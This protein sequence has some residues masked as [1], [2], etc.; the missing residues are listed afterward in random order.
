MVAEPTA[1]L[2]LIIVAWR[3]STVFAKASAK[4]LW[5]AFLR[6]RYKFDIHRSRT[7]LDEEVA[8]GRR[9]QDQPG[10]IVRRRYLQALRDHAE[11]LPMLGHSLPAQGSI[12]NHF[13]EPKL[14]Q[15]SAT[16]PSSSYLGPAEQLAIGSHLI[17]APLGGGKTSLV[18][19]ITLL[20][21]KRCLEASDLPSICN[22]RLPVL[23]NASQL[24]ETG[25][26]FFSAVREA[27]QSTLAGTILASLPNEFF[28]PVHKDGH[29]RWLL[30][31]DGLNQI[32]DELAWQALWKTLKTLPARTGGAFDCLVT[33]Q[34]WQSSRLGAHD[35]TTW[36]I[37]EFSDQNFLT[38]C[39]Q[40]TGDPEK[41]TSMIALV[42]SQGTFR[43]NRSP[44]FATLCSLYYS[45]TGSLPYRKAELL[46]WLIYRL[47][48]RASV[49]SVDE[50]SVLRLLTT[51]A[52]KPDYKPLELVEAFNELRGSETE[53]EYYHRLRMLIEKSGLAQHNGSRFEFNHSSIQTFLKAKS[54]AETNLPHETGW[55]DTAGPIFD[56]DTLSFVF[57]LWEA[58]GQPTSPALKTLARRGDEGFEAAAEIS[59][60]LREVSGDI[61]VQ[62]ASRIITDIN[63]YGSRYKDLE[64]LKRLASTERVAELI[65]DRFDQLE[66][67]QSKVE[68]LGCLVS[69]GLQNKVL[70]LLRSFAKS[71]DHYQGARLSA[72]TLILSWDQHLAKEVFYELAEA[73]DEA[74]VRVEAAHEYHKLEKT[75]DS[76]GLLAAAIEEA[77]ADSM[78]PTS[79][80][81]ELLSGGERDLALAWLRA[82][83]KPRV[84]NSEFGAITSSQVEAA[85]AIANFDQTEGQAA[86]R[87]LVSSDLT[88]PLVGLQAA[89]ALVELGVG[90]EGKNA[91][92]ALVK[93]DKDLKSINATTIRRLM[94][95][96]LEQDAKEVGLEVLKA[97]ISNQGRHYQ[98]KEILRSLRGLV[99][100]TEIIPLLDAHLKHTRDAYLLVCLAY[101]GSRETAVSRLKNWAKHAAPLLRVSSSIALCELG[102]TTVGRRQL[103]KILRSR[104]TCVDVR[105]AA[106]RGLVDTAGLKIDLSPYVELLKD[107][108][109]CLDT[110]LHAAYAIANSKV[111]GFND[112]AWSIS[113]DLLAGDFSVSDRISILKNMLKFP[114]AAWDDGDYLDVVDELYGLFREAK[115]DTSEWWSLAELLFDQSELSIDQILNSA[116]SSLSNQSASS[117][118]GL[119]SRRDFRHDGRVIE[120]IINSIELFEVPGRL[121]AI[122]A[123][124]AAQVSPVRLKPI[125]GAYFDN[126]DIPPEWKFKLIALLPEAV[127]ELIKLAESQNLTIDL[128]LRAVKDI[129]DLGHGE[130]AQLQLRAFLASGTLE[131]VDYVD[132]LDT[133]LRIEA[134]DVC[135]E[136]VRLIMDHDPTAISSV[137]ESFLEF[138][139]SQRAANVLTQAIDRAKDPDDICR[140]VQSVST[141]VRLNRVDTARSLLGNIPTAAGIDLEAD[142]ASAWALVD[143]QVSEQLLQSLVQKLQRGHGGYSFSHWIMSI[144]T[145]YEAGAAVDLSILFG[146]IEDENLAVRDRLTALRV[147]LAA[148]MGLSES[149]T[150]TARSVILNLLKRRLD[151]SSKVSL[152]RPMRELDMDAFTDSLIATLVEDATGSNLARSDLG[153][154]LLRDG[155]PLGLR[156]GLAMAMV[157]AEFP[158]G[159][160][161]RHYVSKT[162]GEQKMLHLLREKFDC[163][164]NNLSAKVAAAADL[165]AANGDP[166]A[167]RFMKSVS[168]EQTE[169][170]SQFVLMAEDALFEIGFVS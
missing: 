102:M 112:L 138:D 111:D 108:H 125:I 19:W 25:Q 81:D 137:A 79:I 105:L 24:I 117:A 90:D 32:D 149:Q 51:V 63:N 78:H 98:I 107:D 115:P 144:E 84:E 71:Q 43:L 58:S 146:A 75:P 153:L 67:E 21:C 121:R 7:P 77:I 11:R 133:A 61:A 35:F 42:K 164:Q 86:L 145:V 154:L 167:V 50:K 158:L 123:L 116:E 140:L 155:Y 82:E 101:I 26:D 5:S 53:L 99:T 13:V 142:V 127:D 59:S 83:C 95:L 15:I 170:E 60:N 9:F 76:R 6:L 119:L 103:W 126:P 89:S 36:A 134:D 118:L 56:T 129:H 161:G 48:K 130:Y 38:L 88:H 104:E 163:N 46:E 150:S 29:A 74:F 1:A 168:A 148:P 33:T 87:R 94:E 100:E 17:V 10:I 106:A 41:A 128:R 12:E 85:I 31:V 131:A 166:L 143:K 3:A 22:V 114:D 62:I 122:A 44:L 27:A 57:E 65:I 73:A 124:T 30:V 39:R 16:R 40:L 23:V 91:Y 92:R 110:K 20:E 136:V 64:R 160:A 70:P 18:R 2:R 139:Q 152:L 135:E 37:E 169:R 109:S 157:A 113:W 132:I 97:C 96:G 93:N 8:V 151:F 147:A 49:S 72:A 159:F 69:A 28:N 80:L 55:A 165:A 14:R 162:I 52:L 120:L 156:S 141:L 45:E 34:P 54:V 66:D 4:L 68:L 47:I